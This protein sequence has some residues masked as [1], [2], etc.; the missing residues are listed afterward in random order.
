MDSAVA[1][2]K[3]VDEGCSLETATARLWPGT[4]RRSCCSPGAL[5]RAARTAA[6]LGLPHHVLDL[7][8]EFDDA[9]VAPFVRGY[10][11]GETPNPCVDCNPMRLAALVELA[12]ELGLPRLAT[13]HYARL[14][15][16]AGEAWV[17]RAADLTKDQSYMLWAVPPR[18]WRGSS[19]RSGGSP[20]PRYAPR[21]RTRRL[22]VAD[23][24]ESQEVCFAADGYQAFLKS[25]GVEPATGDVVD[26]EGAVI[27]R[28]EGHWRFTIGQR[29]GIGLSAAEPLYVLER[30]AAENEVVVGGRPLLEARS[31]AC[32]TSST[33]RW[34]AAKDSRCSSAI[35]RRPCP[36]P[37]SSG[38]APSS[39]SPCA[40]RSRGSRPARRPSSTVTTS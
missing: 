32:A 25:R 33:A 30:R 38:A 24:P 7:E 6:Q 35:G 14:V 10:L 22:E 21:P 13:G 27:G 3:L 29:R 5:Q 2:L 26:E 36:S 40:S 39:R 1:A 19:S 28:H 20:R 12:G 31:C 15:W 34:R 16:R 37:P 11:A 18:C 8:G 4:D 23:E 9:V 17:A